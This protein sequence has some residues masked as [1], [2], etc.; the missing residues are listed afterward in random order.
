MLPEIDFVTEVID[1]QP[2]GADQRLITLACPEIAQRAQPGQFVTLSCS[3][4]LRRPLG[5]ARIDQSRGTISV[6]GRAKG[7]GMADIL[8]LVP[9]AEVKVLGP[10]G[11]GYDLDGLTGAIVVGGGT[12][13]YPMLFLLDELRKRGL[14]SGAAFGFRS[15]AHSVLTD[16][17][18]EVADYCVIASE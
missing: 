12:G 18:K 13:V 3:R 9:G 6:G 17:F 2:L 4:F 10:L 15:R 1:N 7:K 14:K 5:I 11:H 16:D 8:A